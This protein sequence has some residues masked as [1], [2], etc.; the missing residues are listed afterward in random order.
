M[1]TEYIN[2]NETSIANLP[3]AEDMSINDYFIIQP[4][5]FNNKAQLLQ[6]KNL[7]FGLDNVS[8]ASTIQQHSTDI[9][10][11]SAGNFNIQNHSITT[12]KLAL[13]SVTNDRISNNSI[14][15][16]KLQDGCVG[17][18]KLD[19]DIQTKINAA[20]TSLT[21]SGGEPVDLSKYVRVD[22]KGSNDPQA[23]IDFVIK[24]DESSS[25]T[26][27]FYINT[28]QNKVNWAGVY[29]K[30]YTCY[31]LYRS[32]WCEAA[33]TVLTCDSAGDEQLGKSS[34]GYQRITI[35]VRFGD[36]T[37]IIFTC[38]LGYNSS[39]QGGFDSELYNW[40]E[41][42]NEGTYIYISGIRTITNWRACGFVATDW[43]DNLLK[44]SE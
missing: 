39:G 22:I 10:S 34:N 14:S 19:T 6:F 7:I 44:S 38:T 28:A 9:N 24:T 26:P 32:G 29:F 4:Q 41:I 20:T 13:N 11:L 31:R 25:I 37:S 17:W 36:K 35:P 16:N 1:A 30:N 12:D 3:K 5:S 15:L 40:R 23:N 27:A 21:G 42:S 8:F 43:K 2:Y 18:N 33:G